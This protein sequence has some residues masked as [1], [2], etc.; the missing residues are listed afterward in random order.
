MHGDRH[1]ASPTRLF[2]F[3][4]GSWI[5]VTHLDYKNPRPACAFLYPHVAACEPSSKRVREKST[6]RA[7]QVLKLTDYHIP[8]HGRPKHTH[9]NPVPTQHFP[10]LSG[11]WIRVTHLDYKNPRPACTFLYPHV[12]ACEPS[13]KRVREKST[14]RA[15]QVLKLT[16]YHISRHVVSTFKRLTTTTTHY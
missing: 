12:A 15:D 3:L 6:P 5:R 11:S 8:R 13:S 4:S 9:G 14:P 1:L 16:D 10:F 2:P 7:D